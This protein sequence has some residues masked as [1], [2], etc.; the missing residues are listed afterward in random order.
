VSGLDTVERERADLRPT[1]REIAAGWLFGDVAGQPARRLESPRAALQ[2]AIRPMLQRPPCVV[3]F[4]G[5]RDSSALLACASDLAAREG[6]AAPVAVT[7]RF[8]YPQTHESSWQ[9]LVVS[10]LRVEDW[11]REPLVD[12]LDCVGPLAAG[13]LR[14]HGLLFPANVHIIAALAA[15]GRG[16]SLLTGLEA[17]FIFGTWPW[18]DLAG[19]LAGRVAPRPAHARRLARALAP[20]WLDAEILVRREPLRL[21]WLREPHRS[22]LALQLAR[23]R[24]RIPR[25]WSRRVAHF[26]RVRSSQACA[27]S[28]AV[29]GADHDV[30]VG[31]PFVDAGFLAALARAGGRR[32]WGN[33]TATMQALFGDLLPDEILARRGKATF[34]D[35]FLASATRR[36]A[37]TWDGRTGIDPDLVDGDVLREVWLGPNPHF[38]SAMLL[39]AAW[40]A[41]QQTACENPAGA[42]RGEAPVTDAGGRDGDGPMVAQENTR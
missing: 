30:L 23:E 11:V 14:R 12:E 36:F 37:G 19:V 6:L 13:V 24:G 17:D 22:S 38:G 5:G 7:L 26:A 34:T 18:H 20:A 10:H 16:G 32:G 21:P 31:S 15:H 1:R 27:W 42:P 8:P 28:A 40:L 29:V 35:A 25:T 3:A 4:S 41:T 2:A 39:Q 9:E 33:R